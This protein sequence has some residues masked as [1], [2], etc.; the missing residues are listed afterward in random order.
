MHPAK[1]KYSALL[2]LMAILFGSLAYSQNVGI[3]PL[4]NYHLKKEG[5]FILN[6]KTRIV[7][8]SDNDT[9]K[10]TAGYLNASISKEL[11]VLLETVNDSKIS[12]NTIFLKINSGDTLGREGYHLS[13][14]KDR[15]EISANSQNG[16]FYGVISLMQLIP[17]SISKDNGFKLDSSKSSINPDSHGEE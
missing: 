5:K 10:N 17:L 3:I 14:L 2:L 9:L 8:I 7:F 1:L 6:A 16:L 11:G 13:I 12:K 4:P 15:I